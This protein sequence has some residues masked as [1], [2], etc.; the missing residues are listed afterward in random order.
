GLN[1]SILD[2]GWYEIRRQLAYKQLWR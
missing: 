1:R 2:Q